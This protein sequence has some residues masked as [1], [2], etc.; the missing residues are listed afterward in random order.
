MQPRKVLAVDDSKLVLKMYEVMLKDYAVVTA[1]DGVEALTRLTEHPDVD[2]V[3]LDINMPNMNGL[4]V[5]DTLQSQGRLPGL[6][7]VV[8]TT[9]GGEGEVARGLGAGAAAYITKPFDGPNLL[10]LIAGLPARSQS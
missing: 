6:A 3:L 8:V 9:E 1:A 7:V 4:E 2:L 10:G 5:L